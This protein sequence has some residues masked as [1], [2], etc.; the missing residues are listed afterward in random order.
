M[1]VLTHKRL[2]HIIG[3]II[4]HKLRAHLSLYLLG[5]LKLH[6]LRLL[7]LLSWV[8]STKVVIILKNPK[9]HLKHLLHSILLSYDFL[10]DLFLS[11]F[12]DA[13]SWRFFCLDLR[14]FSGPFG[15]FSL[16]R[17]PYP[18]TKVNLSLNPLLPLLVFRLL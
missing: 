9:K 18:G 1:L 11:L 7:K 3:F 10:F 16:D 12:L 5:F 8:L 4:A 15:F 17:S 13:R 6:A 14:Y 2:V